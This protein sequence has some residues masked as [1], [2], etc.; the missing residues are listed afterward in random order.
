MRGFVNGQVREVLVEIRQLSGLS[1]ARGDRTVVGHPRAY[2]EPL[3]VQISG[4]IS[5]EESVAAEVELLF[6]P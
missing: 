1:R 6:M 2:N 3:L 5:A 4:H